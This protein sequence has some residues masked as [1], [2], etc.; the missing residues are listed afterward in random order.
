MYHDDLF[1]MYGKSQSM[2]C[3]PET[4]IAP[5]VNDT[6]VSTRMCVYVC[7]YVHIHKH[8]YIPRNVKG[9]HNEQVLQYG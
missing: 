5:W 8:T 3:A 1:A 7:V 2:C 4:T 6:S 9:T